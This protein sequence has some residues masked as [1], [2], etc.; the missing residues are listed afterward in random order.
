M[1]NRVFVNRLN[2][3]GVVRTL[4]GFLDVPVIIAA[5]G[6]YPYGPNLEFPEYI[7]KTELNKQVF[8]NSCSAAIFTDE[9][10]E[11]YDGRVYPH[12]YKENVTGAVH[13]VKS[14][15]NGEQIVGRV[16]IWGQTA[17]N[18]ILNSSVVQVSIGYQCQNSSTG[19]VFEG[20]E[21]KTYQ[22]NLRVNHLALVP[23]GRSG[24]KTRI[25]L[26]AKKSSDIAIDIGL[27]P[28]ENMQTEDTNSDT[29]IQNVVQKTVA[30]LKFNALPTV[31]TPAPVAETTKANTMEMMQASIMQLQTNQNDVMTMLND[32]KAN[33]GGYGADKGGSDEGGRIEDKDD[34]DTMNNAMKMKDYQNSLKELKA[35]A[36]THYTLTGQRT[37]GESPEAIY[38][39]ILK[40]SEFNAYKFNGLP[41]MKLGVE[42]M[43]HLKTA[44]QNDPQVPVDNWDR[45]ILNKQNSK[46]GGEALSD[47][48]SMAPVYKEA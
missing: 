23:E 42:L 39:E 33:Y 41:E 8:I 21:Y 2:S 3:S 24:D 6:V 12:N 4:E 5:E 14:V 31:P 35:A 28:E 36:D 37:G 7:P 18:K 27:Q 15:N 38:S 22:K 40:Q 45:K 1:Q 17:I 13:C 25:L 32:I 29:H 16:R 10:P 43:K 48:F 11:S 34:D 46:D 9:H 19:G 47:D 26:N 20:Q 30:Q 44:K